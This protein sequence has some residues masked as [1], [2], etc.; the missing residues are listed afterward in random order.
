MN[1]KEKLAAKKAELL[2]LKEKIENGDSE[3][4][5]KASDLADEIKELEV[6]V[7]NAEKAEAMLKSIGT[8]AKTEEVADEN[9]AKGMKALQKKAKEVDRSKKGWSIGANFKAATDPIT[10]VQITD[11]DREVIPQPR[12]NRVADLL[13]QAHI[14]GNAVTYFSENGWQGDSPDV[15]AEGTKKPQGSTGFTPHTEALVKIAGYVKET[16]EVLDDNDFLADSVDEAM[17]YRLVAKENAY[18]IGKIK[19]AADSEQSI[20]YGENA[21]VDT[22][23]DGILK[24][25]TNIDANTAYTANVVFLHPTDY[26]N[27]IVAKD[28]NGQYYGGGYFSGAYGNGN[29]GATYTPWGLQAFVDGNVTEGTAIVCA[30]QGAMKFYRKNDVAVRVYDQNED[31]AVYNRVTIVAEERVLAAIKAP[32]VIWTVEALE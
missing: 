10:S 32:A 15:V 26:Y 8:N 7:K 6:N 22:L 11:Y 16:D 30:T 28:Q 12:V 9:S 23:A 19:S 13:T 20:T 3:A 29:Y 17:R 21:D 31:D 25:K 2:S 14:S 5:T 1:L 27:L 18:V 24:A 4:I